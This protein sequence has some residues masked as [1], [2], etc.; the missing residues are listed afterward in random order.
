M[1]GFLEDEK[2]NP[3]QKCS[4]HNIDKDYYCFDCNVN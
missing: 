2:I 3:K 4:V 1:L